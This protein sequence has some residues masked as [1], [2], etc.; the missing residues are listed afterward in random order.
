MDGQRRKEHGFTLIEMSIVLVIIGL[1]VGGV[2]VGQDLI[3]AAAERAQITQIEKLN[4]AVNTFKGKYGGIPGDLP[5]PLATQFGFSVGANCAGAQGQR[6]GNGLI[7]GYPGQPLL[8]GSG[9]TAAFW[10]DISSAN[11]IDGQFP[12]SGGAAFN[13]TGANASVMTATPGSSY[14]GNYLP[15]AKIGQDNFV[16]VYENSGFNWYGV[17]A[18]T[19]NRNTG[20]MI[21][22]ATLAVMQAYN[23]DKK[24]DDGLPTTGAVQATYITANN[25]I[26]LQNAPNGPTDTA[27]TCYS[28]SGTTYAYS[29]SA[30]AKGG[31]GQNC[32]LSFRFQ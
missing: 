30:T 26:T 15:T 7:D 24:V 23:I 11:F 18:V 6:D 25:T 9:E 32:A 4:A 13:C 17:S 21:S 8:Q 31:T 29:L 12:N 27:S 22:S 5:V 14:V 19:S 28:G 20:G 3:V 16:Y 1:I 10:G 2:L